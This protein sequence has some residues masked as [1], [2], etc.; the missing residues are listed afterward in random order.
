MCAYIHTFGSEALKEV[1][2]HTPLVGSALLS[3]ERDMANNREKKRNRE[4][5]RG[6]CVKLSPCQVSAAI[7]GFWQPE[8]AR[9]ERARACV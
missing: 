9:V 1:D 6:R 7:A 4:K 3:F 8:T 2:T 5:E